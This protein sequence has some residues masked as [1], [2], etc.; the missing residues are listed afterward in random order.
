[1]KVDQMNKIS[2]KCKKF[3]D[4]QSFCGKIYISKKCVQ[5]SL[6]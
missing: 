3:S 2:G 5:K 1:M 4:L 6:I